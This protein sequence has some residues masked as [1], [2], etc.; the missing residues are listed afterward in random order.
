MTRKKAVELKTLNSKICDRNF[1][2][3]SMRVRFG[4]FLFC[5]GILKAIE[6]KHKKKE[7]GGGQRK[8]KT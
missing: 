6:R 5:D 1:P 4:Q 8:N 7:R 2:C 3:V